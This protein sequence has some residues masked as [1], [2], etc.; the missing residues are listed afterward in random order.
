MLFAVTP[1]LHTWTV[2]VNQYCTRGG[3]GVN[4]FI[5]DTMVAKHKIENCI[6]IAQQFCPGF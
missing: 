6:E 4:L 3:E 2:K 5:L 1:E